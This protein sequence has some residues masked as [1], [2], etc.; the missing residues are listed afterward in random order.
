MYDQTLKYLS[1]KHRMKL[2]RN[3]DQ[4]TDISNIL[5]E[6]ISTVPAA[7]TDL[8]KFDYEAETTNDEQLPLLVQIMMHNTRGNK[9]YIKGKCNSLHPPYAAIVAK[10]ILRHF[11]QEEI[12]PFH[13][14]VMCNVD[15]TIISGHFFRRKSPRYRERQNITAKPK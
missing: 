15:A 2:V 11:I 5:K 13:I 3:L 8:V 12:H 1:L 6:G 14:F 4:R 7:S 9:Q 10:N